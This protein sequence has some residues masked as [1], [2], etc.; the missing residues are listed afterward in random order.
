[1]WFIRSRLGENENDDDFDVV[2]AK[3]DEYFV[4]RRNVIH[5]WAC[6]HQRIQRPGEK[7]ETFIRALY[8]LSEHCDFS[9][10]REENIRDRI[11]VGILDKD[12]KASANEGPD[13]SSDD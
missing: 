4:P 9:A 8:E 10:N 13:P 11:V 6:F 5:E 12:V 1:M 3:F 2:L 7:A